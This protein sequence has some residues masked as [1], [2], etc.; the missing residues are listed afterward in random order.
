[1]A[2]DGIEL[3]CVDEIYYVLLTLREAKRKREKA[4]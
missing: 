2:K 4:A 3:D 1:M